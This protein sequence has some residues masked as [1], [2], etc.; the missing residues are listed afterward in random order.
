MDSVSGVK[1]AN[2]AALCSIKT[3]VEKVLHDA[4]IATNSI[5]AATKF[6]RARN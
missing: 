5:Y 4:S 1:L 6:K 3:L 2:A